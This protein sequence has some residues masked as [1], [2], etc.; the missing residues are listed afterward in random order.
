MPLSLAS[1]SSTPSMSNVTSAIVDIP[2]LDTATQAPRDDFLLPLVD[3]RRPRV[4]VDD[5]AARVGIEHVLDLLAVD[6]DISLATTIVN[7]V[8]VISHR[9]LPPRR[10]R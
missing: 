8:D 6:K 7:G 5:S 4:I 10:A 3:F 9:S 2:Y 1:S